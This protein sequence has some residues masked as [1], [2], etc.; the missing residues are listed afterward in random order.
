MMGPPTACNRDRAFGT[1][2]RVSARTPTLPGHQL[3]PGLLS[4][5]VEVGTGVRKDE[6][7]SSEGKDLGEAGSGP[8]LS[9]RP[10]NKPGSDAL[11]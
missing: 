5:R 9:L 8:V 11:T 1:V 6:W 2:R 7:R 10:A 3:T 4:G